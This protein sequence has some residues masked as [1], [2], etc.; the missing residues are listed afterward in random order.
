MANILVVF[1]ESTNLI[2]ASSGSACHRIRITPI[3]FFSNE[4]TNVVEA[5]IQLTGASLVSDKAPVGIS[6]QSPDLTSDCR[7][8]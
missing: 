6:H 7:P 5:G 3:V 8:T 4:R 2:V 1:C